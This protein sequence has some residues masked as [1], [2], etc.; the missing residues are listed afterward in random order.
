MSDSNISS[1]VP[2]PSD[3]GRRGPPRKY[4]LDSMNVGESF[5]VPAESAPGVRASIKYF[6]AKNPSFSFV[7]RK[8]SD[9]G[10]RIWRVA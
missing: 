8:E 1:S 7:T 10:L 6:R 3:A 5:A 2:I 4:P 9:G